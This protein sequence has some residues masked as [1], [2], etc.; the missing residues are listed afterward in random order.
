MGA[1]LELKG[2][3]AAALGLEDG[4]PV[5]SVAQHPS[6]SDAYLVTRIL[7]YALEYAEGVE[8]SSGLASTDQPP[9]WQRDPTGR[10]EAWIDVGTPSA[11]RLHKSSEIVLYALDPSEVALVVSDLIRRMQWQLTRTEGTVYPDTDDGSFP[12]AVEARSWPVG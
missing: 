4:A 6:E 5:W 2:R 9:V 1:A 8:F 12:L 11:T 10:L 3:V 7:A